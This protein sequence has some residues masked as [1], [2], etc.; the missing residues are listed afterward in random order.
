M[1]EDLI[2]QEGV[3]SLA[4]TLGLTYADIDG[5]GDLDVVIGSSAD[6]ILVLV[7]NGSG[8]FTTGPRISVGEHPKRV[9]VSDLDADGHPR[10]YRL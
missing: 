2:N 4:A 6:F 5:D 9:A 8:V 3:F 1:Q 7:N 10:H